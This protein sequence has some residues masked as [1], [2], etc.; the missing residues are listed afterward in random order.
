M[1]LRLLVEKQY[2]RVLAEEIYGF[3]HPNVARPSRW[4]SLADICTCWLGCVDREGRS[5][6]T[7]ECSPT[8]QCQ[9]ENTHCVSGRRLVGQVDIRC[10][11]T[12]GGSARNRL[13]RCYLQVTTELYWP[14]LSTGSRSGEVMSMTPTQSQTTLRA[15]NRINVHLPAQYGY[16]DALRCKCDV[17]MTDQFC[18]VYVRHMNGEKSTAVQAE[19]D[20][21]SA[22][23]K[24]VFRYS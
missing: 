12:R 6:F 3:I 19:S 5:V 2:M 13:Y 14:D 17:C 7:D 10:R 1:G 15:R 4:R 20:L 16:R 8:R 11:C 21:E 23:A 18:L 22:T 24:C 9:G